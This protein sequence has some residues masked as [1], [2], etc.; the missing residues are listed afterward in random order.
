MTMNAATG[1][2]ITPD[3]HLVQ[4]CAIILRTP[5]GSRVM[6]GDFGSLLVELLAQ[7]MNRLG[8]VRLYA[9][10]ATALAKWEPRLRLRAV[11]IER[12]A[13]PG[14]YWVELQ[15]ERR[16]RPGPNTLTRLRIPIETRPALPNS[17]T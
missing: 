15:A 10:I 5:L 13:V 17:P 11:A 6:R 12:G 3:A 14:A 1:S 9:A 7:P 2:T 16:D 8:Q 4:S